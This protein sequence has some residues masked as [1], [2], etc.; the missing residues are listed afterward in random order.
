MELTPGQVGTGNRSRI[1]GQEEWKFGESGLV[2]D[3]KA[4]PT[5]LTISNRGTE[6]SKPT[7]TFKWRATKEQF[8]VRPELTSLPELFA[9]LFD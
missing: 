9:G 2:R 7:K 3:A 4:I 6:I 5:K 8:T 1:T